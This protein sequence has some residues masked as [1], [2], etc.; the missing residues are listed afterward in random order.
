M[1]ARVLIDGTCRAEVLVLE[2]RMSFW[3][4]VDP[5]TGEITDPH[6]PQCGESARGRII[7]L[8]GTRGSSGAPGALANTF[9]LGNGPAAIVIAEP[10]LTIVTAVLV[11][12]LL[13]QRGVPVLVLPLE[14]QRAFRTG[15][16]ADIASGGEISI[17]D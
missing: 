17:R 7:V 1:K 8:P 12:D 15:N 4:G 6:H 11:V 2:E 5:D 9:R 14:Q 16:V 3:T 13:Y 10:S